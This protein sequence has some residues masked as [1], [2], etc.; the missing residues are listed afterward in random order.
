MAYD[1]IVV[2][3]GPAGLSAALW[4]ARYRRRVLVVDSGEPRNRWTEQTHGYFGSDPV[5]P[6]DLLERARADLAAYPAAE[7]CEGKVVEVTGGDGTFTLALDSGERFDAR[8]LVLATGV[9]DV[10]PEV[11]SFFEHYGASVFHCPTCDGFEARDRRVVVFG[12]SA[13]VAGFALE[14]DHWA[15]TITVV[16][17][18]RPFEGDEVH[19]AALTDVGIEILEDDAVALVGT[20]GD[21]RGVKLRGGVE[22]SCD[23]AFFSIA[24]RSHDE[25]A[26]QLGCQRTEAGCVRVDDRNETS[27]PGVFAA[28]DLTPGIQ[29]VQVAAAKGAVAGISCA[30]TLAGNDRR[31]PSP[32]PGGSN[33]Y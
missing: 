15:S 1:A 5:A 22:I 28:G 31:Q 8:R 30:Q 12:W 21:L 18:G 2:G 7:R 9:G 14:L 4:L 13:Q 25:L 10:F 33:S 20:R 6:R 23:L 26:R 3:G 27:V 32:R 24:H 16:T 17:D 29:L 11:E 19:R